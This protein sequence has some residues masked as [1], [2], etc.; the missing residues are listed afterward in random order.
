MNNSHGS[1][2]AATHKGEY[3]A[4]IN[5]GSDGE[6]RYGPN[7]EYR[8]FRAAVFDGQYV[9]FVPPPRQP[10]EA[11]SAKGRPPGFGIVRYDTARTGY[12]PNRQTQP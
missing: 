9:Y 12:L 11:A 10:W 8:S 4:A 1:G 7:G 5:D 6:Y 2:R 3:A